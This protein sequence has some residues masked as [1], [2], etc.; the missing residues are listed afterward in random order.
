[1]PEVPLGTEN[2]HEKAPEPSVPSEPPVQ[3]TMATPSRTRPTVLET[4]NPVPATVTAAPTGPWPGVTEIAVGVTVKVPEAV[5]PPPFVATTEVPDVPLGTANV[6]LNEPVAPAVSEPLVQLEIETLSKT[7]DASAA[8]PVKFVPATVT[9]A[10]TGP[11][12]GVTVIAGTP[13]VTGT[14]K[15][16]P[17]TV[18]PPVEDQ[19]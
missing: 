13:K 8:E 17:L 10:P 7:S 19:T 1:M 9:A 14:P 12:A 4:E 6:Q 18:N 16:A 2:V 15:L 3:L 11:W 5:W